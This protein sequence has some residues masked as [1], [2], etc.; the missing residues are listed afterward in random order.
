MATSIFPWQTPMSCHR[1]PAVVIQRAIAKHLKILG[2]APLR[3]FGIVE[4]VHHADAF[5][6]LLR[7]TVEFHWRGDMC[8]LQDRGHKI[9]HVVELPPYAPLVLDARRP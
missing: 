5:D 9:D 7:H 2:V 1:D 8:R 6:W 3:G 4:A